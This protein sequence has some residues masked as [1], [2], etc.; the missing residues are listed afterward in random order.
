MHVSQI[1]G[2]RK[3]RRPSGD[4]RPMRLHGSLH[5]FAKAG[6]GR[7][8]RWETANFIRNRT[9]WTDCDII[10][11]NCLVRGKT[12]KPNLVQIHPLGA[13][14]QMSEIHWF[15]ATFIRP[16]Y[17]LFSDSPTGQTG[18]ILRAVAQNTWKHAIMCIFGV[19]NNKVNIKPL[20]PKPPEL[21]RKLYLFF[22][23]KRWTIISDA[24]EQTT[25]NHR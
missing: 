16:I 3:H 7:T 25:V 6:C 18:W 1:G 8:S 14:S 17:H 9:P 12:L 4:R 19:I 11:L 15:C 21:D 5:I 24:A 22:D 2:P 20:S 23:R 10:W 13:F